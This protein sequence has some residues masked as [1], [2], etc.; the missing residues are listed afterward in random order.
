[1]QTFNFFTKPAR[2]ALVVIPNA[3]FADARRSV[4]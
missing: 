2:P 1:M 3:G 4:A